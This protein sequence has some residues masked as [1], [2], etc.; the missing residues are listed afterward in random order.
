VEKLREARKAFKQVR[1]DTGAFKEGGAFGWLDTAGKD[2]H[3]MPADSVSPMSRTH[4]PAVRMD[5][6]DH[7]R[8]R[9]YGSAPGKQISTLDDFKREMDRDIRELQRRWP[10]KYDKGIAEMR[11][12]A[13]QLEKHGLLPGQRLGPAELHRLELLKAELTAE[14]GSAAAAAAKVAAITAA[15]GASSPSTACG[16]E[17]SSDCATEPSA[18]EEDEAGPSVLGVLAD[19]LV[20]TAKE[21]W[22]NPEASGADV[23]TGLLW[24]AAKTLDPAVFTDVIEYGTGFSAD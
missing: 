17:G 14:L 23:A 19:V 7:A 24:D 5:P 1:K 12:Y 15:L 6:A 18:E 22:E 10:G 2:R 13:R 20:P 21:M 3:H 16:S 8:T 9:T 11:Q 4:G